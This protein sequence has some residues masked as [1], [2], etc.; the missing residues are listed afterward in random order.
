MVR[1]FSKSCRAGLTSRFPKLSF[2]KDSLDLFAGVLLGHF[3]EPYER[4]EN[5]L[6]IILVGIHDFERNWNP[7]GTTVKSF[8]NTGSGGIK[9]SQ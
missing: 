7:G 1:A 4:L 3:F 9:G 2:V 8:N 5:R 6:L